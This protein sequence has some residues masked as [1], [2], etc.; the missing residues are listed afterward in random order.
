MLLHLGLFTLIS[1]G[2]VVFWGYV[3]VGLPGLMLGY[4]LL[5]TPALLLVV[6]FAGPG[7]RRLLALPP[8]LLENTIRATPY[9]FG[10]TAGALMAGLALMVAIWT[11]GGAAMRD[12]ISNIRFPDAFVTGL[13]IQPE[14]RQKLDALPFVTRTS[15]VGMYGVEI[16]DFGIKR[17]TR[18]KTFFV[19]FEPRSFFEM[20]GLTWVQGDPETAATAIERGGA[21]IV[22]RE[23]L[24]AKGKGVGGTFTCW[25]GETEHSFDI[26]GVVASPG[27]EMI[28][29]MYD[30]GAGFADQRI[31]AVFGGMKDLKE[32]F[33]SEA[34]RMIQLDLAPDADEAESLARI[35]EELFPYGVLM[36]GSGREIKNELLRFVNTALYVSSMVA[37]FAMTVCCFGVANL[38]IA[39]VQARRFEFGVLR[40]VGA[41]PGLLTRLVLG[42]AAL[43]ALT[44]CLLGTLMG[45]QG[46]F[47][48]TRLN[49]LLWGIEVVAKPP[50]GPIAVGWGA[51]FALSILAAAPAIISLGRARPREL[52]GAVRG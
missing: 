20:S 51:I 2:D 19:G 50:P 26:V 3:T 32:K 7:L 31:H 37:V 34:I 46:A 22:S 42:E 14:A 43:I 17:V 9:R 13:A 28:G 36:A 44:A 11:Q 35:R 39:G 40:A 47:G 5:G 10:F 21:V 45:V 1:E 27:L 18:L 12:W 52:L 48:G 41:Q 38:I 16:E 29:D 23:F 30:V 15:P 24:A 33:N 49:H 4:F 8:G 6:R 25:D